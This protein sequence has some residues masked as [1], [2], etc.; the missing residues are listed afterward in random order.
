[1]RTKL[2]KPKPARPKSNYVYPVDWN[3]EYGFCKGMVG[4]HAFNRKFYM[5]RRGSTLL[6]HD[7]CM[8]CPMKRTDA[9][10]YLSGLKQRPPQYAVP[11]G[12]YH[13]EKQGEKPTRAEM[14]RDFLRYA[15]KRRS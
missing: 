11:K 4:N 14:R 10:D 12:Y 15:L 9:V 8:N 1:L 3:P 7:E 13:K 5:E 6:I 2:R